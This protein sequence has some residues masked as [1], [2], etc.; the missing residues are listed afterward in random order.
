MSCPN[1]RSCIEWIESIIPQAFKST[2]PEDTQPIL[3]IEIGHYGLLNADELIIQ[4]AST[5]PSEASSI[6]NGHHEL[7]NADELMKQTT[8]EIGH[9][10][11]LNAEDLMKQTTS[12]T[13]S[14]SSGSPPGSPTELNVK[15]L[16]R[17]YAIKARPAST[18]LLQSTAVEKYGNT[19]HE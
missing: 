6:A 2:E 18:G 13:S 12:E 17:S 19:D 5:T 7:L 14:M 8:S 10:E 15:K 1:C 16:V 3:N 11:L 4:A 9:H